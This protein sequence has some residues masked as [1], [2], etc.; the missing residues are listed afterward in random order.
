ME[1]KP[2]LLAYTH[3]GVNNDP[4]QAVNQLLERLERWK[5]VENVDQLIQLD[6]CAKTCGEG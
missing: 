5:E 1:L 2:K 4:E 3:Y 6:I